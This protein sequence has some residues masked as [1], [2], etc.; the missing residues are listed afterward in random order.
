[1]YLHIKR[2]LDVSIA[3]IAGIVLLPL[4][5][6][7]LIAVTLDSPGPALF[8]QERVGEGK[9][10]FLLYKFR[11]MRIDTPHDLPTHL[12]GDSGKYVTRVGRVL[13]RFSLDELPQLWN[14][15]IGDMSFVGPR[16]ALWNQFDLI[17]E[18]DMYVGRYGKSPNDLRPGLTGWAQI[19]GRDMIDI[20]HKARLD[21]EYAK[22]IS[23]RFDLGCLFRTARTV[24]GGE[25]YLKPEE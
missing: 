24:A 13:R 7:L 4:F 11:T 16:P 25:G 14:I 10:L 12:L 1:M 6:I 23:F 17:A 5:L 15:L 18:R 21:G 19:N 22:R 20:P 9:R 3:L 2:V 8:T